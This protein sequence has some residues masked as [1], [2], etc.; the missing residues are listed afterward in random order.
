MAELALELWGARMVHEFMQ[1]AWASAT[2][3]DKRALAADVLARVRAEITNINSSIDHGGIRWMASQA[4]AIH[5]KT[6]AEEIGR[7]IMGPLG[8]RIRAEVE[9][10]IGKVV[11]E[12]GK[13][14]GRE[15]VDRI[16]REIRGK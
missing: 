14:F 15:L 13:E 9:A 3:E 1:E 2:P 16:V 4:V 6:V 8:D 5:A 10:S 11:D 7:S 12:V